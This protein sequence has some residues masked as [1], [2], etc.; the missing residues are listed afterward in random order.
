MFGRYLFREFSKVPFAG[1]SSSPLSQP[2]VHQIDTL[3]D[4]MHD[5]RA[6]LEYLDH[7]FIMVS[8]SAAR[9]VQPD[10]STNPT[11][12]ML[13]S[14][15]KLD[16]LVELLTTVGQWDQLTSMTDDVKAAAGP[17]TTSLEMLQRNADVLLQKKQLGDEPS[18][19]LRLWSEDTYHLPISQH[20]I[21]EAHA[22]QGR[23]YADPWRPWKYC[24]DMETDAE[25]L[26]HCHDTETTSSEYPLTVAD[27]VFIPTLPALMDASVF[28]RSHLGE[29]K[30]LL[31]SDADGLIRRLTEQYSLDRPEAGALLLDVVKPETQDYLKPYFERFERAPKLKVPKRSRVNNV[32]QSK[33]DRPM[34]SEPRKE[35][36]LP[37]PVTSQSQDSPETKEPAKEKNSK[38][39]TEGGIKT[40][41][42]QPLPQPR[43]RGIKRASP[44]SPTDT[45]AADAPRIKRAR[46][47]SLDD[48]PSRVMRTAVGPSQAKRAIRSP[49]P[50]PAKRATAV[51]AKAKKPAAAP[52]PTPAPAP[53]RAPILTPAPAPAPAPKTPAPEE[54]PEE[55]PE[56]VMMWRHGAR[57]RIPLTKG[58]A[59][60]RAPAANKRKA[61]ASTK[62]TKNDRVQK[63]AAPKKKKTSGAAAPS[64]SSSPQEESSFASSSA[65]LASETSASATAPR[66]RAAPPAPRPR[67]ADVRK[68]FKL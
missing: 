18:V 40:K 46:T 32:E 56:T 36:G 2:A 39:D 34:K 5:V 27:K 26:A 66:R 67:K 11:V 41:K 51:P 13:V 17:E 21:T 33:K 63:R 42:P 55:E 49:A 64:S 62:N 7:P 8:D 68:L 57:V 3:V 23:V 58:I 1:P 44:S 53:A 30:S 12:D 31:C 20:S 22:I 38:P 47:D 6:M 10:E 54:A 59:R 43:P 37:S 15:S 50:A 61:A 65:T 25:L 19:F 60:P 29:T 28:Q 45:E 48:T 24:S 16:Y 9:W 4:S 14:T 52:A 35:S